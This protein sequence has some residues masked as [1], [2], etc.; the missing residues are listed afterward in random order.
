MKKFAF[1]SAALAVTVLSGL[2][3]TASATEVNYNTPISCQE[4]LTRLS[5]ELQ[6]SLQYHNL[7]EATQYY[8]QAKTS[9]AAG[10]ELACH[11]AAGMGE[12]DMVRY[13]HG[14]HDPFGK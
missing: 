7:A 3:A 5:A 6:T 10:N 13:R 1:A 11:N 4:E 2:A 14:Y 8:N 12:L 9:L